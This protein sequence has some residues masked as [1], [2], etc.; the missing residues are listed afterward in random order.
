MELDDIQV[1]TLLM[2]ADSGS[3]HHCGVDPTGGERVDGGGAGGRRRHRGHS[4]FPE[5]SFDQLQPR[6]ATGNYEA[7][8]ARCKRLE[9]PLDYDP[10]GN[11]EHKDGMGDYT[12][13]DP[14][15]V[16]AVTRVEKTESVLP[17]GAVFH[18][19]FDGDAND[20]VG[21]AQAT[22]SG[23]VIYPDGQIGDGV[24]VAE[25]TENLVKNPSFEVDSVGWAPAC[26][27]TVSRTTPDAH[28]GSASLQATSGGGQTYAQASYG[29]IPISDT[30][31]S[32]S[33]SLKNISVP[34][35]RR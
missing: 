17:E 16:H 20:V 26:L 11:I 32:F 2:Y 7:S 3:V 6:L 25:A 22:T 1:V 29:Q 8:G 27:G 28:V 14:A 30:D 34:T 19:P 5:D 4:L 23:G 18:A 33:V 24:Q 21:N 31:Y 13:G 12:Y 9:G 15:H 35:G 10:I